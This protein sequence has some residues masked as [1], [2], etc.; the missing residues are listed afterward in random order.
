MEKIMILG[1][2]LFVS[3]LTHT[4]ANTN[5]LTVTVKDLQNSEGTAIFALYNKEGTIPDEKFGSYFKKGKVKLKDKF[6]QFT[7]DN[8][9]SGRYAVVVLHDENNNDKLDK[10]FMLPIPNEGIG[11]SNYEDFGIGNRPNFTNASF[12]L[13]NDLTIDIKV[14]Y[15]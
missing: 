5:S 7:F 10:K 14:I 8:L 3:L 11:F 9:P 15:K 1:I 13:N 12:L 2:V 6:A 4:T